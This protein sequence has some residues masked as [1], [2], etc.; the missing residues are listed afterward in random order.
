MQGVTTVVGIFCYPLDTVRRRVMMQA[1][2]SNGEF[3]Y[4]SGYDCMKVIL[5]DEGIRGFYVGYSAN[6]IRG[7]GGALLL[8]GYDEVKPFFKDILLTQNNNNDTSYNVASQ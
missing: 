5:K 1:Q 4:R 8:V 6:F 3:I 7:I 2:S